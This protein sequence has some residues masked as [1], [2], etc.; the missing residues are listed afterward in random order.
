MGKD[1]NTTQLVEILE[2]LDPREAKLLHAA[3][4][5]KN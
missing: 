4:N 2:S 3:D 1:Y 5:A